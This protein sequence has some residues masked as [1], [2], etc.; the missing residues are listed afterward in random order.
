MEETEQSV[1]IEIF[2][3]ADEAPEHL[4]DPA[5]QVRPV[6][7]VD[8]GSL[9]LG[10]LH[11]VSVH[12]AVL[13]SEQPVCGQLDEPDPGGPEHDVPMVPG[14][15]DEHRA[16]GM[17]EHPMELHGRV[18]GEVVGLP[19]D[20]VR[21]GPVPVDPEDGAFL[22]VDRGHDGVQPPLDPPHEPGAGETVG[23]AVSLGWGQAQP[24]S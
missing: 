17:L 2:V 15:G 6:D 9:E 10:D 11:D 12:A 14:H 7:A 19:P 21:G 4:L 16:Q 1:G 18:V 5:A 20:G 8:E 22:P 13:L 3:P 23:E 24:R